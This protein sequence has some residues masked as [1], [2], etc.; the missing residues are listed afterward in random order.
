MTYDELTDDGVQ[1]LIEH[2]VHQASMDYWRARGSRI[3]AGGEEKS[4]LETDCERFFRSKWFHTLT[5]MDGRPILE[6]LQRRIDRGDHPPRISYK[7][8]DGDDD[9]EGLF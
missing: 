6:E 3:K 2:V 1:R 8:E 5:G 7:T 9:D 4:G